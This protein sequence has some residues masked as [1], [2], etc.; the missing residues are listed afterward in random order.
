LIILSTKVKNAEFAQHIIALA[1][2]LSLTRLVLRQLNHLPSLVGLI[3][4]RKELQNSNDKLDTGMNAT[5]TAIYTVQVFVEF[6]A[7]IADAKLIGLDAVKWFR[8]ALYLVGLNYVLFKNPFL[9]DCCHVCRR[10]EATTADFLPR[11]FT[12]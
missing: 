5:V 3:R 11:T 12:R 1:K 4:A 8:W 10:C 6:S 2:Q 7:W 9:V